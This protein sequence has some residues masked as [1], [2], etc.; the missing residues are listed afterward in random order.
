[1]FLFDKYS[2]YDMDI[3]TSILLYVINIFS[4]EYSKYDMNI[5]TYD[6]LCY[7]IQKN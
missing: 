1:M 5:M 3:M 6:C 2:E 4:D 7:L